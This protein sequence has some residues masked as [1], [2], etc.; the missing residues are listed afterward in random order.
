MTGFKSFEEWADA[1]ADPSI[2]L[3]FAE[4]KGRSDSEHITCP[5]CHKE[6]AL[7][8][9]SSVHKRGGGGKCRTAGCLEWIS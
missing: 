3:W 2:H 4:H 6:G 5:K 1:M 9:Q 7:R 8:L